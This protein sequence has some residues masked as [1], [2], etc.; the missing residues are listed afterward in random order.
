MPMKQFL[1]AACCA[2]LAFSAAAQRAKPP[3]GSGC[4]G[5]PLD[6]VATLPVF[7]FGRRTMDPE[8][9]P[10][11]GINSV[12]VTCTRAP[13]A[14]GHTVEVRYTLKA[15]P[16]EPTR[17]MRSRD[18][19]SLSYLRYYLFLDPARTRQWGD[20]LQFGTFAIEDRMLLDDRNRTVT[21]SHVIYGTV[22]GYQAVSPAPFLGA[23]VNRLQ[24]E[25]LCT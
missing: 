23:V 17:S 9:P 24:Y 15:E 4:E 13:Q 19:G 12:S 5:K 1:S 21:R 6:C 7:D 22:D 16:A 18:L 20:G 11:H 2:L 10:I 14:N 8:T 25:F 3:T